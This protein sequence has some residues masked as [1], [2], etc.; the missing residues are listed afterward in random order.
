MATASC[1]QETNNRINETIS[2]K[3]NMPSVNRDAIKATV[4]GV[5]TNRLGSCTRTQTKPIEGTA[6]K[7]EEACCSINLR[8][9][10]MYSVHDNDANENITVCGNID[11]KKG[12]SITGDD[13][14]NG[15]Y[16]VNVNGR[17]VPV[18]N[19]ISV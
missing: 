4:R 11:I 15:S 9:L 13:I 10:N 3:G 1:S 18:N 14:P 19:T 2:V 16:T 7:A 17:V 6:E 12:C 8:E 5:Y